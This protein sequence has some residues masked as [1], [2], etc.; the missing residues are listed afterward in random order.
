MRAAWH[1]TWQQRWQSLSM[2][3]QRGVM[4]V[5]VMLLLVVCWQVLL[6][7]AQR[8]LRQAQTQG[9]VLAQQL[10]QMQAL[11]PQV[12]ALR[13]RTPLS[14]EMALKTLQSITTHPSMQLNPQGDRV[15]VTLKGV[16]A[17][18]LSEWL[19]QS[20]TQAQAIPN[21]VHLTRTASAWDGSLVLVLPRDNPARA[22]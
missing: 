19:A 18:V 21:E 4:V 13:Q 6:A 2:R 5:A 10:A 1:N 11:Q 7:P 9:P 16:P 3:E 17:Q 12:H 15:M 8:T 14:R 20:R 22:K